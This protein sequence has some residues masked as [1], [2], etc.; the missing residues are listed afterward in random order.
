MAQ[1]CCL[2]RQNTSRKVDERE[3]HGISDR[4]NVRSLPDFSRSSFSSE[5]RENE[6]VGMVKM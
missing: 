2:D 3:S 5:Q 4:Q 6:D 1:K